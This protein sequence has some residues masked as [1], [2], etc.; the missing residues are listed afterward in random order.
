MAQQET[1]TDIIRRMRILLADR[2]KHE[3]MWPKVVAH[4]PLTDPELSKLKE[5]LQAVVGMILAAEVI[6][7]SITK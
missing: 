4:G 2:R 6:R 5:E 3:R 1:S 7:Q